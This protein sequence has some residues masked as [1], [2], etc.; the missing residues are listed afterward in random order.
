MLLLFMFTRRARTCTEILKYFGQSRE[1]EIYA[2]SA[3]SRVNDMTTTMEKFHAVIDPPI[4]FCIYTQCA[5]PPNSPQQIQIPHTYAD[6]IHKNWLCH[7]HTRNNISLPPAA[8]NSSRFVHIIC[9][10][11]IIFGRF[12]V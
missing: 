6:T 5:N 8:I 4:Y 3:R 10:R 7:H 9:V 11:G 12:V 1:R 2:P